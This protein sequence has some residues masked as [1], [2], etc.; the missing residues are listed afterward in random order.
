MI[1]AIAIQ[2]KHGII[3]ETASDSMDAPVGSGRKNA[4]GFLLMEVV[5]F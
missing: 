3:K 2:S 1:M 5:V 4:G